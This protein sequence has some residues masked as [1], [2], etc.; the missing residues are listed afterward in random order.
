M[1]DNLRGALWILLAATCAAAMS[2][3]IRGLAGVIPL[4]EIV[5][6]RCAVGIALVL[7]F[8]WRSG[9][10]NIRTRQWKLVLLRSV[11]T[12]GA[13]SAGFYSMTVLPLATA[14]VLFFTA[15]LW[16]TILSIPFFGE[17]VG[18]R[19][20]LATVAGFVGAVIVLRPGIGE[21]DYNMLF[22]I[23]SSMIFAVVLLLGKKLSKTDTI[24]TMMIYAM[25]VTTAASMPFA[26]TQWQMPGLFEWILLL[27]V[28]GFGTLRGFSDTKGYATGEA[29][30]MAP[31]QYSRIVVVAVAAYFLFDEVPDVPTIF[32]AGIIIA[33]SLYIAQRETKLGRGGANAPKTGV[34]AP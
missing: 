7:A 16:V 15:P 27:A 13:L 11:L 5:F 21:F 2:L 31:F 34:G 8:S 12:V 25:V 22:A 4:M 23:G 18:W 33:S 28:A 32:G 19:R 14:T 1:T 6:V 3:A 20:G 29:S 30:V 26:I 9:S 17:K 24:S 10:I